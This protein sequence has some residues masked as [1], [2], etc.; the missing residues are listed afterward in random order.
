MLEH[1]KVIGL[2]SDIGP[3]DRFFWFT[4]TGW[5][6]WNFLVSGLLV[7][8]ELVLFDGDPNHAGPE[9]LWQLAA[10]ERITWFGGGAPFYTACRR[11]GLVPGDRFDLTDLRAVGSTGAPLPADAFRWIY[12]SVSADV[13]LSPISVAPM[14][15]R[16]SSGAV[17]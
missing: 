13:M 15:V 4:T 16:R 6:M 11:A 10:D 5:M 2:H 14:S 3:A 7:G 17:R 8:A 9:T 1:L 12:E